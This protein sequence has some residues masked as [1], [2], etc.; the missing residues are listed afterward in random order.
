M[1]V[2]NM[3][4]ILPAILCAMLVLPVFATPV[5][6]IDGCNTTM[7]TKIDQLYQGPVFLDAYWTESS[8]S[9]NTDSTDIIEREVGPAEGKVTLAVVFLNRSLL[10]I[11]AI[12]G[13]LS[14]PP[15]F[16]AS[17]TSMY[18][19]SEA[20]MSANGKRVGFNAPAVAT[21]DAIVAAKSSFTLYFDID[22]TDK[23]KVGTQMS[24]LVLQYY[25][26]DKPGLC[27]SALIIFPLVLSGK[28]ILDITTDDN[29]LTPKVPN[30][31]NI[32]IVNKGTADATGVVAAIVGLGDS[33]TRSQNNDDGS[34]VLQSSD[35]EIINL[36]DKVFNIGTIPV[37]GTVNVSTIIFPGSEAA[38][39]VQNMNIQLIYGN[40]HGDSQ[41]IIIGTGLV[42]LPN[43]MDT[44]INVAYEN[45]RDS[46]IL[47]AE[48]LEDFNLI[49]TNNSPTLLSDVI[50]SIVP[51]STSITM[52]GDSKWTISSLEPDEQKKISAKVIAA[53]SMI[54][55][56]TSFTVNLNYV[57]EGEEKTDSLNLGAFITGDINLQIFD[58]TVNYVGD[59]P[60]IVGSVL[61]QGNTNALYTSVELIS[62]KQNKNG[63]ISPQ[64]IG[65]VSSDSSIPFSIPTPDLL[66]K[67]T[68]PLTF[69]ISYADNLKN[70]HDAIFE[71]QVNFEPKIDRQERKQGG[72]D[73]Q[74]LIP[75]II[76]GA[77][78]PSAIV[79]I[80]KRKKPSHANQSNF[81]SEIDALLDEHSKKSED[82][83]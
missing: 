15:G 19:D 63:T 18:T 32:S 25:L 44:S 22:I 5:H 42:I 67:G 64:Y 6:A 54:S 30:K 26:T 29:Y 4:K 46:Y 16:E 37:N 45:T 33:G 14:M 57:S 82:K 52:V 78:I 80:K 47:T 74:L 65:D 3:S 35:T 70:F 23:A 66:K 20:I 41:N 51:Q 7:T 38:G 71:S 73:M 61:N 21:Y 10:D 27:T 2:H 81:E 72:L 56:P 11:S 49:V 43:P 62:P 77:A 83:K 69:K 68:N 59:T 50:V 58:V 12:S 31:V 55:T 9:L 75:I 60:N 28:T 24:R 17:G 8:Q 39:T 36:G 40:A 79:I 13:F 1:Q 53:K 76:A 48:K 34:V